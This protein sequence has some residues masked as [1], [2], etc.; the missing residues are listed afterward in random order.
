MIGCSSFP[1]C[2]NLYALYCLFEAQRVDITF[3][4]KMSS[5]HVV[6]SSPMEMYI[7]GYALLKVS[8]VWDTVRSSCSFDALVSSLTD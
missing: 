1:S 2:S 7:F 3:V 6:L 4:E 8:A 5:D